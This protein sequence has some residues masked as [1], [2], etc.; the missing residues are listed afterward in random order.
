MKY[1]LTIWTD[2]GF[3][4]EL[5]VPYPPDFTPHLSGH[6]SF[7]HITDS[8]DVEW[9]FNWTHVLGGTIKQIE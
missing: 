3:K 4:R 9:F 6:R 2:D 1:H 8:D 7:I 5:D